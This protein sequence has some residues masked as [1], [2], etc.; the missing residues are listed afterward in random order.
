[1][2]PSHVSSLKKAVV[3]Q[4]L[5]G[6]HQ[7]SMSRCD[8][9]HAAGQLLCPMQVC[10]TALSPVLPFRSSVHLA[11]LAWLLEATEALAG[12]ERG[13]G[14]EHYLPGSS[15]LPPQNQAHAPLQKAMMTGP[16]LQL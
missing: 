5:C 10:L 2:G 6:E 4:V 9:S 7:R 8:L 14:L 16:L 3:S 12:L 1:M 11:T 15:F 13:K